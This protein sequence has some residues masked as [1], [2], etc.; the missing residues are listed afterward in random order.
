M[1]NDHF[2]ISVG[3]VLPS[4]LFLGFLLAPDPTGVT[5][6]LLGAVL[7]AVLSVGIHLSGWSPG[8]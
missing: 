1:G 2:G 6:L 5:S 3:I 4:G 8:T 7:G